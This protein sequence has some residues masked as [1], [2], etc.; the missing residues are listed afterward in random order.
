MVCVTFIQKIEEFSYVYE[1]KVY[2]YYYERWREATSYIQYLV[3]N[4]IQAI[5]KQCKK[6]FCF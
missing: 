4:H 1:N 5:L 6:T 3:G 2:L